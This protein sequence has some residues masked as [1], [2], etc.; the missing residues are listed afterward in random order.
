VSKGPAS[1]FEGKLVSVP[2][3]YLDIDDKGVSDST[4]EERFEDYLILIREDKAQLVNHNNT[5]DIKEAEESSAIA[6]PSQLT[7]KQIKNHLATAP[8]IK[9]EMLTTGISKP[10]RLTLEGP[11]SMRGLFKTIDTFPGIEKRPTKNSDEKYADRYLYDIAAYELSEYLG[12]DLIPV[13][14]EREVDGV[15]GSI[16]FWVENTNSKLEILD[17]GESYYGVCN[18]NAQ[19]NLLTIFDLLI[20][21]H[22][23]NQSNMLFESEYNRLIW[24]DH[25]RSLS[26]HRRLPE[27]IETKNLV[28]NNRVRKALKDLNAEVLRDVLK[29]KLNKDQIRALLYRRGL[30]LKLDRES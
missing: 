12:F 10:Y 5:L 29:G 17:G 24:I 20:F 7:L 13:V 2:G 4:Q 15:K 22:D 21:N 11:V 30:I 6:Y 25:S 19:R 3:F 18:Y 23:R 14:V 28:L 16:Q 8:I 9:K 1:R 27:Y 26:A